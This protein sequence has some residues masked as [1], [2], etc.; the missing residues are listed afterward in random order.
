VAVPPVGGGGGAQASR[1]L[2]DG[3]L[4][5]SFDGTKMDARAVPGAFNAHLVGG[6]WRNVARTLDRDHAAP[7]W[8]E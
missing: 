1:R 3:D 4:A 6:Q 7:A 5:R 8:V 2:T